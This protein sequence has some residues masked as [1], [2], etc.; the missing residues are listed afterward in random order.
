[1]SARALKLAN[2]VLMRGLAG[3]ATLAGERGKMGFRGS[4]RNAVVAVS[5]NL[6]FQWREKISGKSRRI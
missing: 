5:E 1:M 4:E 6:K 2:P 3:L